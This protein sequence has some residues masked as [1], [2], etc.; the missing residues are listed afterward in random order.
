MNAKQHN[1]SQRIATQRKGKNEKEGG[2][3]QNHTAK[4]KK[5]MHASTTY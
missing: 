1:E 4:T 2:E 5:Q 3:K